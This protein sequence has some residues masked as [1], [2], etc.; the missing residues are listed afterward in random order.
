V[1]NRVVLREIEQVAS[2][3]HREQT[4]QFVCDGDDCQH[5]AVWYCKSCRANL[6]DG[7]DRYVHERLSKH[8]RIASK[9]KDQVQICLIHKEEL[10][11]Y[12]E[13]HEV[14]ICS[15]CLSLEH[16]KSCSVKTNAE[17]RFMLEDSVQ[18][19]LPAIERIGKI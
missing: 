4:D 14:M 7:C 19:N 13:S 10:K 12:C 5:H 17:L 8:K 1:I 3:P 15:I 11:L 6:C 9:E 16:Q 18:M 2:D